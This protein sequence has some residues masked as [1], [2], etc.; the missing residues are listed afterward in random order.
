MY[1]GTKR[2]KV[3]PNKKCDKDTAP[4]VVSTASGGARRMQ[5]MHEILSS[6]GKK[7]RA[8]ELSSSVP[9][10]CEFSLIRTFHRVVPT[11]FVLVIEDLCG[12]F[13]N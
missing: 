5:A 1:K 7:G 3:I 10:I 2:N 13:E 11:E 4:G 9:H 6:H 12:K 8:S